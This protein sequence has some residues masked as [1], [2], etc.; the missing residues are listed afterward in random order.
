[1]T[2]HSVLCLNQR[3]KGGSQGRSWCDLIAMWEGVDY[4]FIDE[5]SMIG[6]SFLLKISEALTEAKQS[7]KAF[8]GINIIFTG[9]FAQLLPVGET[10]LFSHID[11]HK[12]KV[13]TK[14][15]QDD[16]FGKLL[17]LLV[18]VVVILNQVMR[19]SGPENEPFIK[20]LS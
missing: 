19:Q 14:H 3:S 17:W 8:G 2:L 7:T 15:G 1:M 13:G 18:K 6:C 9:D 20:L 11:S 16:V 12:K 5:V 10:Q 4:L